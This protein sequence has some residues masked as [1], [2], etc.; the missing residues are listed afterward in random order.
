M[1]TEPLQLADH[2]GA[3]AGR[4]LRTVVLLAWLAVVA[5]LLLLAVDYQIKGDLVR[6][7]KDMR[8]DLDD[9]EED[10]RGTPGRRRRPARLARYRL[11]GIR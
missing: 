11:G 3:P 8:K 2:G 6:A 9:R 10:P 4:G 1:E 7:A 5:A